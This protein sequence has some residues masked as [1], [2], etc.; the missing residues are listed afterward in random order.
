MAG[1]KSTAKTEGP[2]VQLL[3][4]FEHLAVMLI[5]QAFGNVQPVVWVDPDQ[6]RIERG[7]MDLGVSAPRS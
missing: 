5:E 2:P 6:V 7:M 3:Q 1:F 4:G